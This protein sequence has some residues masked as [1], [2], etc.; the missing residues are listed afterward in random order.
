MMRTEGAPAGRAGN[1]AGA[2]LNILVD[3]GTYTCTN[4]GDVAML[5][6]AVARLAA[7]FPGAALHVLT[8]DPSA[9][10]RHCPRVQPVSN[11][12]R[13]VW[14]DDE[15]LVGRF[16]RV[17]PTRASS[18][19]AAAQH[20]IRLKLPTAYH[21]ALVA[22]R[23][24]RRRATGDVGRFL[25]LAARTDLYVAAG[26]GTLADDSRAHALAV[27][28]TAEIARRAGATVALVGQGIGPIGDADLLARMRAVLPAASI[29]GLR[30]RRMGPAILR[31][32]GVAT[33]QIVV[34]GDE[35][36]ELAYRRRPPELGDGLGVHVRFAPLAVDQTYLER[37]RPVLL[38]FAREQR[39]PLIPLP[40]S[41][42]RRGANDC[43]AIAELAGGQ[44]AY[45]PGGATLDTPAHVIGAAGRCRVVVSCAY[46]A[47]VFALSQGVPVICLGRSA[48]YLAK[49]RGL[50]AQFPGGCAVLALDQ[51]AFE[52][53]L[54]AA[55]R[56]AWAIAPSRRFALW[57]RAERQI[58]AGRMVY[59]RLRDL[60]PARAQAG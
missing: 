20:D 57:R 59:R 8:D 54:D 36:I 29:I 7:N 10:A 6:V 12:A 1:G 51:P 37:L 34:T 31:E 45:A 11:A 58:R 26:Q 22:R 16:Q 15:Q 48:Y 19:L 38:G 52:A 18:L 50:R 47:A 42:H 30:E 23:A 17:L 60:V 25:K 46:H 27:L 5:Q 44:E 2:G 33:S 13:L 53:R 28:G 43:R 41:Q 14:L 56:V 40:I 35:A 39:A 21:A 9:L 32:N 4:V 55:L 3:P 49:F 24:L